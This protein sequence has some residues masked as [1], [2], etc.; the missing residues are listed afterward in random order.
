MNNW[1]PVVR[2]TGVGFYIGFCIVGGVF[3]GLWLDGKFD[4]QPVFTL[5]GLFLGLI[6]TFWGVYQMLLPLINNKKERR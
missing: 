3:G 2:L 5:T 4:T 1:G 6:L